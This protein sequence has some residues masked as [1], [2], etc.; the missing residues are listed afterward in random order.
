MKLQAA[1]ISAP[2]RQPAPR[3]YCAQFERWCGRR[4]DERARRV[5]T[6]LE[7]QRLAGVPR[8]LMVCM[9]EGAPDTVKK[10]LADY[11]RYLL[12]FIDKK[13]R[14]PLYLVA[15]RRDDA[16]SLVP[17]RRRYA[18]KDD[19][20]GSY[21]SPIPRK[22]QILG[23]GRS[24]DYCRGLWFCHAI[25]FDGDRFPQRGR[26]LSSHWQAIMP[27]IPISPE[28]MLVVHGHYR[29]RSKI[30]FF[31]ELH[32]RRLWPEV[33]LNLPPSD[34][35]LGLP[36]RGSPGEVSSEELNQ[37]SELSELIELT[38]L[39][40]PAPESCY[41]QSKAVIYPIPIITY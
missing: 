2:R 7:R 23:S 28:S 12:T 5:I 14:F 35:Q 30:N 25:V 11:A 29:A 16:R 36:A 21:S 4:L 32:R 3:N 41:E 18:R 34:L 24:P 39:L 8:R 38:V 22:Q 27:S 33:D 26:K 20:S 31:S 1:H 9:P 40:G 6:V 15:P 17:K 13:G 37:L 10:S 19:F